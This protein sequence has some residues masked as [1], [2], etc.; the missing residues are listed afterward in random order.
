MIINNKEKETTINGFKFL[1]QVLDNNSKNKS[2]VM[3]N[4]S[5]WHQTK[6]LSNFDTFIT[7]LYIKENEKKESKQ[8]NNAIS[9]RS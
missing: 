1:V 3:N 9:K 4:G 6:H 5:V 7:L 2:R 8:R